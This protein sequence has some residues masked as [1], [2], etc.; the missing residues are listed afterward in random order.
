M[1]LVPGVSGVL[2]FEMAPCPQDKPVVCLANQ[3]GSQVECELGNPMKRGAQ[4]RFY[5]ILS[6]LGITLQTTDLAVE[7]ALST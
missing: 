5:L 7:L 6:T 3:N 4:V 1:G 2:E